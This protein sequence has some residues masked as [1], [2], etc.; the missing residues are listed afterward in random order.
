MKTKTIR[1]AFC[2]DKKCDRIAAIKA[3]IGRDD[4]PINLIEAALSDPDE[5]IQKNAKK[6]CQNLVVTPGKVWRGIYNSHPEIVLATI[7]SMRSRN[8]LTPELIVHCLKNNDERVKL[9]AA[10]A[11]ADTAIPPQTVF[12][13]LNSHEYY[14]QIAASY[15]CKGNPEVASR[16]LGILLDIRNNDVHKVA[17]SIEAS[18]PGP[19][20]R[21]PILAPEK[22]YKKCLGDVIVIAKIPDDAIVYGDPIGPCRASKAEIVGIKGSFY[23]EKVGISVYDLTTTYRIGNKV[24]FDEREFKKTDR[25]YNGPGFYFFCEE[26]LAEIYNL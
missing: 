3:C 12:E 22:A 4:I 10:E 13:W 19:H 9:A 21:E 8:E 18:I 25:P 5:D 1:S 6:V 2:S 23:G 24:E 17:L 11:C 26:E 14:Q 15:S 7:R 16:F 20:Y